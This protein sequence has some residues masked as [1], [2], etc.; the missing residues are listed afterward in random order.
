MALLRLFSERFLHLETGAKWSTFGT[1]AVSG[2]RLILPCRNT[3][4][5]GIYQQVDGWDIENSFIFF[6]ADGFQGDTPT[7]CMLGFKLEESDDNTFS[8]SWEVDLWNNLT[9]KYTAGAGDVTARSDTA[10]DS[11]THKHLRMLVTS[12]TVYWDYSSDAMQWTNYTTVPVSTVGL[13]IND[14]KLVIFCGA[15]GADQSS[16][17]LM[18]NINLK[19]KRHHGSEMLAGLMGM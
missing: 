11:V 1:A 2:G 15:W 13:D 10:W 6:E 7:T 16:D 4:G 5:N 8:I 19:G 12:G 18:D 9:A 14:V 3:Y 17:V